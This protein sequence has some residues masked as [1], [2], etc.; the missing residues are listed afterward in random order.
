M[1]LRLASFYIFCSPLLRLLQA[2]LLYHRQLALVD[3]YLVVAVG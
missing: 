2:K 1:K 3:Q